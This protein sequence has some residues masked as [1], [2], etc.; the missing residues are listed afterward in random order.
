[1]AETTQ[2]ANPPASPAS[3]RWCH[4]HK[5]LGEQVRLIQV[6][7]AGSGSGARFFAC[8]GCRQRHNLVP[9]AEQR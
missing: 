6:V 3:I 9:F 1:M 7:E 2:T 4:W 8:A 5:G